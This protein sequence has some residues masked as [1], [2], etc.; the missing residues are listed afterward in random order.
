MSRLSTVTDFTSNIQ[1][2]LVELREES[3]DMGM[4]LFIVLINVV[5]RTI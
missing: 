4:S 3:T 5:T 2:E 1:W